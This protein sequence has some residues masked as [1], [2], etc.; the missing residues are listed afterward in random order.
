MPGL[1]KGARAT[2]TFYDSY[3]S[4]GA[5]TEAVLFSTP[6]GQDGKTKY[7]TNMK[8][9]SQISK[10]TDFEIWGIAAGGEPDITTAD[11]TLFLAGYM[12]LYI[13]GKIYYEAPIKNITAGY[14]MQVWYDGSSAGASNVAANGYQMSNS[15]TTLERRPVIEAAEEFR[16]ELHWEAAGTQNALFWVFL[17]GE[18]RKQL[19]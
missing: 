14:G 11:L 10:D 6:L 13:N 17:H 15:I 18:F 1:G 4:D 3:K 19:Q 12:E 16:I 9:A 2:W 5:A 7:R 8:L